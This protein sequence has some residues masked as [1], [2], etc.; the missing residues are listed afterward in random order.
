MAN[1]SKTVIGDAAQTILS[2]LLAEFREKNLGTEQLRDTY[3]GLSPTALRSTCCADERFSDVDFDLAMEEL[4]AF[5]KVAR[6]NQ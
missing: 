5:G 1:K 4:C 2:A 3:K 6:A